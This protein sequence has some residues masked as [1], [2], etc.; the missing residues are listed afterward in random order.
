MQTAAE[1][2]AAVDATPA[3]SMSFGGDTRAAVGQVH[4]PE[5]PAHGVTIGGAE[6]GP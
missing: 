3:A 4:M 1:L 5:E 6:N 2:A